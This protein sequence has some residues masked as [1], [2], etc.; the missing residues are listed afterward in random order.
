VIFLQIH[1]GNTITQDIINCIE[2]NLS[3]LTVN[4]K[5]ILMT[6]AHNYHNKKITIVDVNIII[7]EI[8]EIYTNIKDKWN[9]LDI[10]NQSEII[11]FF[12]LSHNENVLY[13]DTDCYL[14]DNIIED[15]KSM[16]F[17]KYSTFRVDIF[18]MYNAKQLSNFKDILF[19]IDI[20]IKQFTGIGYIRFVFNCFNYIM[21]NYQYTIIDRKK[22]IHG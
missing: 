18:L 2:T 21:K 13:L 4:D 15:T 3:H 6:N 16:Y 8:F 5:F 7:N 9:D 22:Y 14:N 1:I 20:N 10:R 19:Y 17:P 12:Y 11:R